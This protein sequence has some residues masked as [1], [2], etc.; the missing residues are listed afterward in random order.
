MAYHL[1]GIAWRLLALKAFI[2]R[3]ESALSAEHTDRPNPQC[4][5]SKGVRVAGIL[6]ARAS[7]R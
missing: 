3:G 7:L 5:K 1:R 6:C 2:K 4:P